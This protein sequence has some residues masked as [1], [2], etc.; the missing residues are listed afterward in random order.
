MKRLIATGIASTLMIAMG[1]V[2]LTGSSFATDESWGGSTFSMTVSGYNADGT[3]A[4]RS[5]LGFQTG[6][7]SLHNTFDL[8]TNSIYTVLAGKGA[9]LSES[10]TTGTQTSLD[11]SGKV[12]KNVWA[13]GDCK[14]ISYKYDSN[15]FLIGGDYW[16]KSKE[17]TTVKVDGATKTISERNITTT[18]AAGETDLMFGE[19][20]FRSLVSNYSTKDTNTWE[21]KDKDLS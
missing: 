1:M 3:I 7:D 14:K 18:G 10:S 16:D 20:V 19:L 12:I 6:S 13:D 15:G 9:L 2:C 4:S 8:T 11:Q 21:D 17:T 5:G